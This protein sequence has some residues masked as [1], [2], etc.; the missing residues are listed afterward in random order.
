MVIS[1]FFKCWLVFSVDSFSFGIG[2]ESESVS[3]K[4]NASKIFKKKI[5]KGPVRH[6]FLHKKKK[7]KY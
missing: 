2:F 7:K 1:Y 4:E 6:G 3:R 5:R